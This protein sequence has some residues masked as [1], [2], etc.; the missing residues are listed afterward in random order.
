[1]NQPEPQGMSFSALM[2]DIERGL[3]KIP[4]FQRDFVWT[5][6]KSARLL[7]SILRGYPIGTFILWKTKD[8]LREVRNIGE[9]QLPDT[10]DGDYVQYVLDGQQR[11]TSLFASFHGLGVKRDD[12]ADDFSEM[13]INLSASDDDDL[14]ITDVEG[15]SEGTF[16]RVVDLLKSDFTHLASFPK[17]YHS[18][19]SQYKR[20]LESFQFSVVQ[21]RETPIEVAT[22]IF[23]RINV[24][25]RPLT[26][27]EIMVAKTYDAKRDFDLSKEYETLLDVL[28]DASYDTLSPTVVLQAVSTIL[29]GECTRR[30]ILNIRKDDFIEIWPKAIDAILSA[31]GYFRDCFR[32]PVS[33]LLPYHALLVPFGYFYYKQNEKPTAD[34][35]RFLQ[36]FF[37]RAS[38]GGR[39]TYA[40]ESRLAADVKRVDKILAGDL[41]EYDWPVDTS[42]DFIEKNGWFSAG[43]SYIKALLSVLAFLEPKSFSDNSIVRIS[44]DWLQRANSKNYHH[45]FP[46]AF[47][48]K[49]GVTSPEPNH[50]AN[51]TIV[52]DYLNKRKIRDRAPSA[53][54]REF[55]EA[56]SSLEATLDGHLIRPKQYGV[57][58]DNYKLFFDMRC[59]ALSRLLEERVIRQ[60]IDKMGQKVQ[61]DDFDALEEQA[62]VA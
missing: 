12:R 9:A 7:D 40:L 57:W 51:I 8:R 22:E 49:Q 50:I 5:K 39:Y 43:R 34:Q 38:L 13:Y 16:I 15:L 10:P 19:L 24:S 14:V 26:V 28:R 32:I 35:A 52:D 25:G 58:E 42:R 21:V 2:G 44:N 37:W 3:I 36:D 59:E 27:F 61:T 17:E 56:N 62:D 48:K 53:Y 6:D 30:D 31:V 45:F 41:P 11:L 29:R 18:K 1:M 54:L 4:Q 23:T 20:Q 46:R 33:R 55:A 60:D 47:L